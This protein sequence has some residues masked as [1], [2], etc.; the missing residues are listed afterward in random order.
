[1]QVKIQ[2]LAPHWF[3]EECCRALN[4][5]N[6]HVHSRRSQVCMRTVRKNTYCNKHVS[7]IIVY[8]ST[9]KSQKCT[10]SSW[11]CVFTGDLRTCCAGRCWT[12][13]CRHEC[14]SV[15]ACVVLCCSHWM[16]ACRAVW[17][18]RCRSGSCV[19]WGSAVWP[20]SSP[21][22]SSGSAS[23]SGPPRLVF[24]AGVCMDNSLLSPLCGRRAEM[25]TC[26]KS[27]ESSKLLVCCIAVF[28]F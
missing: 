19:C 14:I 3:S 8:C 21:G 2:L 25:E 10:V 24:A 6:S 9:R 17:T 5:V 1:M 28:C 13:V 22:Q 7:K 12:D 18:G 27:L 16:R 23:Y 26:V 11:R 20:A 4:P 15:Y